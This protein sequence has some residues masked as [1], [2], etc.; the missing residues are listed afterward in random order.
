M[1]ATS[2]TIELGAPVIVLTGMED[3]AELLRLG[4]MLRRKKPPEEEPEEE[5]DDF[6]PE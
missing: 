2:S 5:W 6:F 4:A 1:S 3:E